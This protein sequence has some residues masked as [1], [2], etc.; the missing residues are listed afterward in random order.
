MTSGADLAAGG[1]MPRPAAWPWSGRVFW[2]VL[3]AMLAWRVVAA[4]MLAVTYDESYY[5]VW[6]LSPQASYFD[7]PPL[8]AWAM[9]GSQLVFGNTVWTV[10]FWPLVAGTAFVLIGRLFAGRLYGEEVGNRAGILLALIPIFVGA[11]LLMTP[12]TLLAPCWLAAVALCWEASSASGRRA[13]TMWALCGVCVGLGLLSKYNMILFFPGAA[14]FWLLS[15]GRRAG[16]FWG[17]LLCGFIALLLFSPVVIWN[18]THGW[19]SFAFQTQHGLQGSKP[20][21]M[22]RTFPEFVGGL[23]LIATPVVAGLSLYGVLRGPWREDRRR[24]FLACFCVAILAMFAYSALK[25]RVQAN[26]PMLAFA[27][28]LIILAQDWSTLRAGWRRAAVISLVALDLVGAAYLMLPAQF[29]L[30]VGERSLDAG[31][32][33][34]FI[35]PPGVA[36]AVRE[37]LAASGAD[38][39]CVES[40]QLYGMVSF[41]APDLRGRLLLQHGG[42]RRLPWIDARPYAGR[43]ALLVAIDEPGTWDPDGA[44]TSVRNAGSAKIPFKGLRNVELHFAIAE[45]LDQQRMR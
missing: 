26:W 33:R 43:T 35:V 6:A 12:D 24:T 15:P 36:A 10:R 2:I 14:L 19:A 44:F 23:F 11:G 25:T 22:L 27:T 41:Y 42:Q 18:A 21:A 30:R 4:G 40:Y 7:H 9:A 1:A 39:V 31:R 3:L 32:M 38:V 34:E 16:I 13:W 29:A 20:F 17:T 45:G 5:H 8:V 37:R 28:A